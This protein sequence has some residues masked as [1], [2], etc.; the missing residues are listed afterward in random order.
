MKREENSTK[1]L[2]L[3]RDLIS[4]YEIDIDNC[5]MTDID[6]VSEIAKLMSDH[7]YQ[8]QIS[9]IITYKKSKF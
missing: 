8:L 1:Y 6:W 5:K 7:K 4:F 9:D 3:Q 2:E